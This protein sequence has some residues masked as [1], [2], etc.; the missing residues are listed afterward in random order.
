MPKL[1]SMQFCE[2]GMLG[3]PSNYIISVH[4]VQSHPI[5]RRKRPPIAHIY[6]PVGACGPDPKDAWCRLVSVLL[7]LFHV[8]PPFCLVSSRCRWACR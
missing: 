7:F 3:N 1:D 6:G 2:F 4:R 5:G 8:V